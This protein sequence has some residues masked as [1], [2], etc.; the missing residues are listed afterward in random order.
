M[1]KNTQTSGLVNYIAHSG[2]I[3][4]V[5]GSLTVTGSLNV[6]GGMTGSFQGVATTASYVLNAVSASFATTASYAVSA[7]VATNAVTA[8]H[9]LNAVSASFATTAVTSSFANAFTVAGTLT[10]QTLV[11]QTITSSVDF[12]TGSTRFGSLLANTHAFT[13][14][15]GMTGSLA[16]N[17]NV[18]IGTT[19][20]I[21][22]LNLYGSNQLQ[23]QNATTGNTSADGTRIQLDGS[24]LQ[25]IN[26]E[27]ADI[28]LYTT[29]TERMRITSGGYVGIGTTSPGALLDLGSSYGSPKLYLYNDGTYV[30]GFGIYAN[31]FRNFFDTIDAAGSRM[32]WG[33]QTGGGTFTEFMRLTKD[34]NVGIGTA[35]P[36]AFSNQ[37][38]TTVNGTNYGRIDLM[39]GGVHRTYF[40]GSSGGSG[41]GTQ[42]ATPLTFDTDNTTRLTIASTGEATFSS[43][44]TTGGSLD[45]TGTGNVIT[46]RKASNVPALAWVGATYTALIEGGDY[47]NFYTGGTGGRLYITSGGNVGIG[48]TSPGAKLD[49]VGNTIIRGIIDITQTSATPYARLSGNSNEQGAA[50]NYKIVRHYPVVSLGTK[51]I[52][53]FVDQGNLNSNTIVRIIGHSARFNSAA[54][55]GFTADFGVGHLNTLQHLAIYSNTGNISGIAINAMN[56]EI[57]FTTSYDSATANGLYATIEFMT[58]VPSYS[59]NVAGITMN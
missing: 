38:S 19:S 59:I 45:V 52:I 2:S 3:V 24:N 25:I 50:H 21:S 49:V 22:L 43:S 9:A 1:S 5:S 17:G 16:V 39:S 56:I 44:V 37:T 53:P 26:R 20:P 42:T 10:A 33:K 46:M 31:E 51:L 13:G 11:V 34:G 35:S 4:S 41:L 36:I 23:I 40:Y 32:T 6:T 57:S 58:N 27:S 8:S 7:S 28:I 30:N 15:V 54:P 47:L 29:D 55:I 18:G 48:T 12:V 14:S